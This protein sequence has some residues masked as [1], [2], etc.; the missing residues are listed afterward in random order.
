MDT[1][2]H[3]MPIAELMGGIA[4]M[5]EVGSV[6][7]VGRLL[8]EA[9]A[10]PDAEHVADQIAHHEAWF[11]WATEHEREHGPE[12]LLDRQHPVH[13]NAMKIVRSVKKV[14]LMV[15]AAGG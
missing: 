5:C 2:K 8:R 14:G 4:T 11:E 12:S 6:G 13:L 10:H 3:R 1:K 9:R 15:E 7:V